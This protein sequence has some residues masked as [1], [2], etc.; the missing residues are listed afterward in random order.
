MPTPE[1]LAYAESVRA[2]E[3]Q[4]R[5]L[6]EIRGRTGVLLAGAAIATSFLGGQALDDSG[7]DVLAGLALI[8]FAG[9][10]ALATAIVWPREKAWIFALSARTL[11]ED[12]VDEPRSGDL[13]AMRRF[14]AEKVE[15]HYDANQAKIDELYGLFRWA[16]IAL[17]VE[18]V[19][20]TFKLA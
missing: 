10:V 8:A 17:G 19:L 12:W 1:E 13:T 3:Q 5:M 15:D 18:I 14:L 2:I 9:V 16:A 7:F 4:A 11:L 6:D 20:W